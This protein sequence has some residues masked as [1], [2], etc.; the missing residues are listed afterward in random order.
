MSLRQ[1]TDTSLIYSLQVC[2]G[3]RAIAYS[4]CVS[5]LR[6]CLFVCVYACMRVHVAVPVLSAC[7]DARTQERDG[8]FT[9]RG[10][11]RLLA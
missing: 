3:A 5:V 9:R 4:V 6:V 11:Q 2:T 1:C 7:V 8:A 10:L